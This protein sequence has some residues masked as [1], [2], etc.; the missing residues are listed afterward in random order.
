MSVHKIDGKKC[1]KP[2]DDLMKKQKEKAE[3]IILLEA[4]LRIAIQLKEVYVKEVLKWADREN[5]LS[6][7]ILK[8]KK[9]IKG[10]K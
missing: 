2:I 8:I 5:A 10:L 9:K 3:N 7:R 1:E 4:E 6:L